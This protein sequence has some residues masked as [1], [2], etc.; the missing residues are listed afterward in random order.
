MKGLR[1]Y[2]VGS[3][4]AMVLYLLAQ[5]Y[6]PKP[7]NWDATYVKED[8]IPFGL[9]IL[10]HELESLFPAWLQLPGCRFTIR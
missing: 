10:Y 1:L 6:K 2:L 4:L 9:Y 7:T 5:Y 3:A 8:K